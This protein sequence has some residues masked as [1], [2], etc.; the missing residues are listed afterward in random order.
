MTDLYEEWKA[1]GRPGGS[2]AAWQA[3]QGA[4]ALPQVSGGS[5][6]AP[7]ATPGAP[8]SLED[9]I[10]QGAQGHSED[11]ARFNSGTV[12]GWGQ[13]YYDAAA[14]QAAGRPQ[15]RSM[16]GA[17]VFYDKP[18]ECP[19]GMGP[20]GPNESDPCTSTGYGGAQA[21][22]TAPAVAPA[23]PVSP[24]QPLMTGIQGQTAQVAA[25]SPAVT[26][27]LPQTGMVFGSQAPVSSL[28]S[29]IAPLN[30]TATP[31]QGGLTNMLAGQQ[32][33]KQNAWF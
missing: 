5:V 15:F 8:Q 16:R 1:Q 30:Q 23:A 2:F 9:M 21:S 3:S 33:R 24:L 17:E 10:R 4:Q 7:V 32:K 19:P 6:A 31:Q 12:Q 26:P 18:T 20:S 28:Q 11:F 25:P 14:S 22:Q 13:Q 27:G 29:L